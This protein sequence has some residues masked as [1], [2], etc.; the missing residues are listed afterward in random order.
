MSFLGLGATAGD[1]AQ[2]DSS[3]SVI[4]QDSDDD[5]D[6][7]RDDDIDLGFRRHQ[8]ET[9][10]DNR[11]RHESKEDALYGVF[12][13]AE[14]LPSRSR[15]TPTSAPLFVPA[16]QEP[17]DDS[18]ATEMEETSMMFVSA[19]KSSREPSD[20]V[21]DK[22]KNE[23]EDLQAPAPAAPP[24]ETVEDKQVKK[25]QNAADEYFQSLIQQA[26]SKKKRR[27]LQGEV[28]ELSN[29][30]E[31][32]APS[33]MPMAFG[34]ASSQPDAPFSLPGKKDPSIAKWEKHERGIGSKL[35]F[36]MG[37]RGS[38]GLGSNRQKKK[39]NLGG[40]QDET[41]PATEER[42]DNK[43]AIGAGGEPLAKKGISRPIEVV[44]RPANLGLGFGNFKEQS[45]LKGNRTI[46]AEVRGI[47]LPKIKRKEKGVLDTLDEN[48]MEED[49]DIGPGPSLQ[50]PSSAIPTTQEIM[51]QKA[52]KRRKN[53]KMAP[54]IIPYED[55]VRQQEEAR[56]K[57]PV[58]ID[59]RG[60]LEMSAT[61]AN[62]D[63]LLGK[64]LLFNVNF[65]LNTVENQLHSHSQM[66]KS[67]ER[68]EKSLQ[69]E[70]EDLEQQEEDTRDRRQKLQGALDLIQKVHDLIKGHD[71]GIRANEPLDQVIEW[72]EAL[73]ASFSSQDREDLR[74]W[75]AL[76]PALL[77][78]VLQIKLDR[79]DPLGS[80]EKTKEMLNSIYFIQI[81]DQN[82]SDRR[83]ADEFRFSVL[84]NQ[85]L[86]K[87][88]QVLESNRW[89]PCTE[90][91]VVVD[92]YEYMI[93]LAAS[94]P[95]LQIHD[96]APS[97]PEG[98]VLS[99]GA[100]DKDHV[101]GTARASDL[102][103]IFR[104]RI[105]LETIYP[106]LQNTLTH[107]KP[108][109]AKDGSGLENRLDLWILPWM[110]H[111]DLPAIL[112]NVLSECKRKL[113]SSVSYLQRKVGRGS[114]L[115][116]VQACFTILKPWAR[117]YES[118]QLQRLV[119]E[120]VS[121]YLAR[122]F[123]KQNIRSNPS[124]QDWAS[125]GVAFDLHS[126]GL[127]SEVEFLSL[128]EAELLPRWATKLNGMLMAREVDALGGASSNYASWKSRLLLY[129][130]T[131][132]WASSQKKLRKDPICCGFFYTA[133]RMIELRILSQF[134]ELESLIPHSTNYHVASARRAKAL[135]LG[136]QDDYARTES[137]SKAEVDAR[138]RLR[139]KQIDTPTFR[140]V[141]E[142][143]ANEREILF[144]PRMGGKA[145]RDG[146]QVFL[147]GSVPIYFEGDVLY[148][149]HA[150]NW[151][152]TSLDELFEFT[153]AK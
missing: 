67:T 140:D 47:E 81:K 129:A 74:F 22:T 93:S 27:R 139:R 79:W 124:D 8:Y 40:D 48:D 70:I 114:D 12:R 111:L 26:Q 31:G 69:S 142:E 100:L 61:S 95:S 132:A 1:D 128:V 77:S 43:A 87:I 72:I 14:V 102:A 35:L 115:Q 143:F 62:G 153:L 49:D 9:F 42:V 57:G 89:D 117:V 46:E 37:W 60:P 113:K 127:L 92:I 18:A 110:P 94:D 84:Q 23:R 52:W 91:D 53:K 150:S 136:V 13:Q 133:L 64:E 33:M 15:E 97:T 65:L 28:D 17:A 99:S 147:F 135:H 6:A 5:D 123:A 55:L 38:G 29:R 51:T 39:P 58:I 134:D 41:T 63:H 50:T 68:K 56:S 104:K 109:L 103:E 4:H 82:T 10:G 106:K 107:W 141:V 130:D 145:L 146:K 20:E 7:I 54:K 98:Q 19:T 32:A 90:T 45:Q 36:K 119:S 108:S 80:F 76:A 126:S 118:K 24:E 2:D 59:M 105:I 75:Q 96:N 122:V 16:A 101:G 148:A 25:A 125:V 21:N 138:I 44:V 116:F 83:A 71:H 85:L 11:S 66:V 112:S 144:Q 131:P 86:P 34:K 121:P 78:P 73:G 88:Q 152:P 120:Y 151:R 149:S 3:T 30:Q 137:R